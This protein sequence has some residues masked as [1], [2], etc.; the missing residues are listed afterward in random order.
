VAA[1]SAHTLTKLAATMAAMSIDEVA[2]KFDQDYDAAVSAGAS[3]NE[4]AVL[5]LLSTNILALHDRLLAVEAK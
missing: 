4:L 3:A 1:L 5:R 2:D